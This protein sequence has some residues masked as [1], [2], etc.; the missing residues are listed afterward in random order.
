MTER[1]VIEGWAAR[2][3][4]P[5]LSGDV[6]R[7]GA[8]AKNLIP[9]APGR[10]K[11]LHQHAAEAPVGRWTELREEPDGLFVKGEVFTDTRTGRD[12]H[13]LLTGGALDGLSIGFKPIRAVRTRT[14]RELREVDLWEIS[15]VTFPMVPGARIVRVSDAVPRGPRDLLAGGPG[16]APRDLLAG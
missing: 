9:A 6:I 14:G 13:R 12:L 3:G 10:V 2:F 1:A 11:M 4:V 5:D 8:F 16:E 15:I 7:P